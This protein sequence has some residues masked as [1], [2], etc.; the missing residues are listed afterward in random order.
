MH[1]FRA[2]KPTWFDNDKLTNAA[3]RRGPRDD[4]G[5]S[6][7]SS[8]EAAQSLLSSGKGVAGILITELA[9][10]GFP[11]VETDEIHGYIDNVPPYEENPD[12][13][14]YARSTEVADRLLELA[15][16][17]IVLDRWRR[18]SAPE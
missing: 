12:T 1:V 3:F 2:L 17:G 5:L 6:V 11:L 18:K 15:K 7:A 13:D 9:K 4:D 8:L 16:G 10:S 14:A